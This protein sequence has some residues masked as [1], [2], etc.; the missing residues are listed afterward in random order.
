MTHHL[1]TQL[2][3]PPALLRRSVEAPCSSSD[4]AAKL[5][6]QVFGRWY[7]P[8]ELLMGCCHY[9]CPVDM[10]AAGCVLAELLL[11]RP[12]F[13]GVCDMD[14]LDRI[15]KVGGAAAVAD[16]AG[17]TA[18]SFGCEHL[19]WRCCGR[20]GSAGCAIWTSWTA[21]SRWVVLLPLRYLDGDTA[22]SFGCEH[23]KRCCCCNRGSP[24]C[25]TWTSWTASLQYMSCCCHSW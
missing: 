9:G 6:P 1:M 17:D 19:Q 14:Q 10:W 4:E 5:T 25:A 11:R 8:P 23:L 20:H 13:P 12:W 16:P 2:C 7:R 3:V 22:A 21:S 24:R 15:F 18:A